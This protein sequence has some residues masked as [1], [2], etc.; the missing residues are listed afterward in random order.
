MSDEY[1]GENCVPSER[2]GII[3]YVLYC[4]VRRPLKSMKLKLTPDL[5]SATA[6]HI[7]CEVF[8]NIAP[9]PNR[10]KGSKSQRPS[11]SLPLGGLSAPDAISSELHDII[12][13]ATKV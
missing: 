12:L 3:D 8:I 10:M 5:A 9:K 2:G 11:K 4:T 6:A 1:C 13:K 7:Q